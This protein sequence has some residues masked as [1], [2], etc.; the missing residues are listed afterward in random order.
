MPFS[1]FFSS[2]LRDIRLSRSKIRE[3]DNLRALYLCRFFMEYLLAQRAKPSNVAIRKERIKAR[4]ARKAE[5]TRNKARTAETSTPSDPPITLDDLLAEKNGDKDT[6]D[7]QNKLEG[8]ENDQRED[9]PKEPE[10]E[11]KQ[12][13]EEEEPIDDFD[14]GYVAEMFEEDALRWM[15]S[16][17]N[18]AQEAGVCCEGRAPVWQA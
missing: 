7:G 3:T 2:I 4:E 15:T 17:L 10:E 18:Q 5:Q 13:E 6:A 8:S 9:Q 11:Q 16:R 14:F 12:E 1:A